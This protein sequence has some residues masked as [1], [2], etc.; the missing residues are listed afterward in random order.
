MGKLLNQ[1]KNVEIASQVRVDRLKALGQFRP[2][3][4]HTA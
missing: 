3:L 2:R 4:R 1:T